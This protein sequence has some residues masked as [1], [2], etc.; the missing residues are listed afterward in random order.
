MSFDFSQQTLVRGRAV[1]II[2]ILWIQTEV[3]RSGQPKGYMASEGVRTG[4]W[5]LRFK[6]RVRLSV[7]A[8]CWGS[9]WWVKEQSCR[10]LESDSS[11]WMS[12]PGSD[13]T[14]ATCG[15]GR[16]PL[17]SPDFIPSTV[18]WGSLLLILWFCAPLKFS[19]SCWLWHLQI[20][21]PFATWNKSESGNNGIYYQSAEGR[22]IR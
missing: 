21:E 9:F 2:T 4:M 10:C 22:R 3:Q 14:A 15:H 11:G 6:C 8:I 20:W 16:V 13:H 17:T 18:Q 19:P 5:E 1:T 7:T 12:A